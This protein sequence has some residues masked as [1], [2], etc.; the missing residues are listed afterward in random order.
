VP[1]SAHT[2]YALSQEAP[3]TKGK[4]KAQAKEKGRLVLNRPTARGHKAAL[5]PEPSSSEELSEQVRHAMAG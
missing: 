2:A 3:K 1:T 5:P 4:A